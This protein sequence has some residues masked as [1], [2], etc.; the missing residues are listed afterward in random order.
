MKLKT[1][2][3]MPI[4]DSV[5]GE[6]FITHC[7]AIM[8]TA[9]RQPEYENDICLCCPQ[10]VLPHDRARAEIVRTG[11]TEGRDLLF[12]IDDDMAIPQHAFWTMHKTMIER[13]AAV[14]SGHYYRRGFP[15]T[16]VWQK[17]INGEFFDVDAKD[18]LHEIDFSGLGCA[19]IDLNWLIANVK[20]P[21]FS[22]KLEPGEDSVTVSDDIVFFEKV[23]AANGLVIGNANVRC[24]HLASRQLVCDLT[25]DFL[26]SFHA[27]ITATPISD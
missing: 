24:G 22:M 8:E 27:Q 9:R 1:I 19:L 5:P 11:Y 20:P 21:F 25:A 6:V 17:K 23:E 3:G 18:G 12:F 7:M 15:F 16:S 26:R 10:N 4:V 14:V 13:K 2:I